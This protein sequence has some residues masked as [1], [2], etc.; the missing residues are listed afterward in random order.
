MRLEMF[1]TVKGAVIN[2]S[3]INTLDRQLLTGR[4]KALPAPCVARINERLRL[5]LGV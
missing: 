4:I 5:V 3:Q 1:W 2:V